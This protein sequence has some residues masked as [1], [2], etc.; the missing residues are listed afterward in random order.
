MV[1]I[2]RPR[3]IGCFLSLRIVFRWIP[4]LDNNASF[5]FV[6]RRV[7]VK[8]LRVDP[9]IGRRANGVCPYRLGQFDGCC[10]RVD[11]CRNIRGQQGQEAQN[12]FR[13]GFTFH[14][15]SFCPS[16][17]SRWFHSLLSFSPSFS[18]HS[19]PSF[20]PSFLF[21][22]SPSCLPSFSFHSWPSRSPSPVILRRIRMSPCSDFVTP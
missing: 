19:W 13:H 6:M 22:S 17:M 2:L 14:Y 20:G 5:V 4:N 8:S 18:I 15:L 1:V 7:A 3:G 11:M 10:L 12:Q 9:F 16:P 21:H